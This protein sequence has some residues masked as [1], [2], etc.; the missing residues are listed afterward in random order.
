MVIPIVVSR[1]TLR[2]PKTHITG[3]ERKAP[4][5]KRSYEVTASADKRELP[6]AIA[7]V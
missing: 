4:L 7:K 2:L 5:L 6:I 3:F 1:G